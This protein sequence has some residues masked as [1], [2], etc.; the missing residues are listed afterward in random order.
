MTQGEQRRLRATVRGGYRRTLPGFFALALLLLLPVPP[1]G[2][3]DDP[4][5]DPAPSPLPAAGTH[6][7]RSLAAGTAHAYTVHLAAGDFLRAVAQ[8]RGIDVV[9]RLR[10][11][12]GDLVREVDSPNGTRGPERL[13]F[14]AELAGRHRLE[15]ASGYPDAADG[16]Y[17]L[18]VSAL[19]PARPEDEKLTAAEA[20][21]QQAILDVFVTATAESRRRAV[22]LY[23]RALETWR[24][25]GM[26]E[27]EAEA[28]NALAFL[29]DRLGDLEA[30][31]EAFRHS[32]ELRRRLGDR[33]ETARAAF[34]LGAAYDRLGRGESA[35][36]LYRR[37]L[38]VFEELGDRPRAASIWNNLGSLLRRRGRLEAALDAFGRSLA[39]RRELGDRRGQA[40][41][42]NNAGLVHG[43]L[44]RTD[45][46]ME[47]FREAAR[48]ARAADDDRGLAAALNNLG[49]AHEDQGRYHEALELYR[50]V[51]EV[52]QRRGNRRG[53]AYALNN[54]GT[55]HHRLGQLDEALRYY[56]HTLE[57]NRETGDR[58]A[59]AR[60]LSNLGWTL[61]KLGRPE[62]A[63]ARLR[64][65]LELA[66]ELEVPQ[67]EGSV[68]VQLGMVA[69]ERGEV[70]DAREF[71]AAGLA[72]GRRVG[73]PLLEAA[74]LVEVGSLDA[75]AGSPET[76]LRELRGGLA[77]Y[78]AA[79]HPVGEARALFEIA[80]VERAEGD[81]EAALGSL[82]A[83]LDRVES[84]RRGVAVLELRSSL[85]A[86]RRDYHEAHVDLLMLLHERQPEAGWAERAFAAAERARARSLLDLLRESQVEVRRGADPTLLAR[87]DELGRRLN[88][89]ERTRLQLLA[90]G[91]PD[92]ARLA[93]LEA[94]LHEVQADH[95]WVRAEIRRSSPRY[96]ALTQPQVPGAGEIR[97][98]LDPDTVLLAYSLGEERSFLWALTA[99]RLTSHELP[100]RSTVE[101]TARAFHEALSRGPGGDAA[102][103]GRELSAMVLAP[104]A[105][106]LAGRRLAVVPDGALHFVPF[107]ALADPATDAGRPVVAAHEVIHLPSS[108]ALR[109]LRR[110][111]EEAGERRDHRL[112]VIADP[113]FEPS[114]PRVSRALAADG[115]RSAEIRG[116]EDALD[117]RRLRFSR[118]E[119]QRIAALVPPGDRF[120]ALGFDARRAA[121]SG[122]RLAPYRYVHFATHGV[123][124]GDF[125]EL[126]GLVLSLVGP[127]GEPL[128]GFLRL[129]DVYNLD[130]DAEVVT[131]SA[132]RT[133]LG[134]EVRGEGLV[135]LTRGFMYAGARRVVASLWDV[136]DRATAE[137]MER[138]YRG[139]IEDGLAPAAAL[140]RAQLDL[141]REG[142]WS[143]PYYW[144]PFV[145]QGDWR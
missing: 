101:S 56:R 128:D 27:R 2:G 122:D 82:E 133:A 102:A 97:D 40:L 119:A 78:R 6:V 141:W 20:A 116:A 12:G 126:S 36:T 19:R 59:E 44:G 70:E 107:A 69:R 63:H 26:V 22:D 89:L 42:L 50:Q 110:E 8:Q 111:Q 34:N 37:S 13:S 64:E 53:E 113:V 114:D 52:E 79:E 106:R 54:L 112:A 80:R 71:L 129:H 51:R 45:R 87:E 124:R 24:E 73:L 94:A 29:H 137:I 138:F 93:E 136:Q 55:V 68:L 127:G 61:D 3:V 130:L 117:F 104:A 41:V 108:A 1:A 103:R 7:D 75:E 33:G 16:E 91:E 115:E 98:L 120:Q 49:T 47:M 143:E 66:R 123:L 134:Q 14:V 125:P 62:E 132:C 46:A 30:A 105:R 84:L 118:R 131:L 144:A 92:P 96:A 60:T 86:L 48:L 17:T 77:R 135:G 99:D 38:E 140:R 31:A 100:P 35:E 145:L 18:S 83:S 39:L 139:M 58:P 88:A 121:V 76:A 74:A 9:V 57:L 142:R 65:A 95:R 10:E 81:L 21:E 23:R 90:G 11:P 72:L 28:W 32:L 15:V 5:S 109:L 25:L 85:F 43:D 67:L 4:P